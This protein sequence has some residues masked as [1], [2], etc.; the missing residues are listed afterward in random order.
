MSAAATREDVH[1]LATVTDLSS[2]CR[3]RAASLLMARAIL[4]PNTHVLVIVR[5]ARWINNGTLPP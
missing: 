4:P 1:K 2:E 5:V 3:R